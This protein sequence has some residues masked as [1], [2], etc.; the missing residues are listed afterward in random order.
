MPTENLGELA[1]ALAKAQ[2]EFP[3]IHR[4]K[5]VTVKTKTGGS[6]TFSYAPLDSILSAVR[7][8]LAKNGLVVIQTLDEGALVTA[9]IHASGASMSGAIALP[10]AA[11]IQGLGSAITYL[12]RYALQAILGIAAEEDDDG[13][14]ATDNLV[15]PAPERTD[16]GGLI[17]IVEKG[18]SKDSDLQ[19]RETPDGWAIGFKL[20]ANG[21]GGIK[22]VARDAL[23]Q[24]IASWSTQLVGQRVTCWGSIRD[25]T[26]TP[27]NSTRKVTYQVLELARLATPDFTLPAAASGEPVEAPSEPLFE[28]DPEERD[29]IAAG[30]PE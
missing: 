11:D 28:L 5:T 27:K 6:Y 10:E 30:L 13:N 19:L 26:F 22:V 1:A 25:E 21:R 4:D 8:P 2:T 20:K 3:T 16:D 15:I 24:A 18:T 17:G 7:V 14:R 9:L 29:A 23:A 12:R